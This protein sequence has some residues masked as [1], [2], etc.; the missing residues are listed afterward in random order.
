MSDNNLPHNFEKIVER[1]QE[2]TSLP[3]TRTKVLALI[4]CQKSKSE[5]ADLLGITE[6][7]VQNHIQDLRNEI[8]FAQELIDIAGRT[9]Y[10]DSSLYKELGGALWMFRSGL[11]YEKNADTTIEKKIYG[12]PHGAC[13]L[14]EREIT[15][16]QGSISEERKRTEFYEGNDIPPHLFRAGQYESYDLALL[17]IAFVAEA[18]IDP[19]YGPEE[20]ASDEVELPDEDYFESVT[21]LKQEADDGWVMLSDL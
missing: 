10:D 1:L 17:H 21:E 7:T 2:R 3:P 13:L 18:G 8:E 6:R 16:N 19:K 12:S 4:K 15:E 11:R 5:I 14:V 20:L 9:H